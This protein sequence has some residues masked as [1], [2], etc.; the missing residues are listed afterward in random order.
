[1]KLKKNYFQLNN[2][3]NKNRLY[4]NS[5]SYKLF[6]EPYLEAQFDIS[7]NVPE[8]QINKK[9]NV[10]KKIFKNNHNHYKQ[11]FFSDFEICLAMF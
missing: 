10:L 9:Y 4:F 2:Y 8:F 11:P 1:M 3:S 5:N 7:K 6:K